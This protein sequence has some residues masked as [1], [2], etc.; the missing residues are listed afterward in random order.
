MLPIYNVII[1]LCI[2]E[3]NELFC[4]GY[5]KNI[6]SNSNTNITNSNFSIDDNTK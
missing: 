1:Y 6:D 5:G 2:V 4:F 3:M